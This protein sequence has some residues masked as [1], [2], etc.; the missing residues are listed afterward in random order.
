[1][2]PDEVVAFHAD[3]H[4]PSGRSAAPWTP[5]TGTASIVGVTDVGAALPTTAAGRA[6][7]SMWERSSADRSG[8]TGT[9]T[10]PA[11]QTATVATTIAGDVGSATTTVSSRATPTSRSRRARSAAAA[12]SVAAVSSSPVAASTTRTASGS[13]RA[14]RA[15]RSPIGVSTPVA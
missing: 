6:R 11:F 1:M 4:R 14:R 2:L 3:A 8:E 10:P 7:S 15:T 12:S 9:G 13:R 5:S